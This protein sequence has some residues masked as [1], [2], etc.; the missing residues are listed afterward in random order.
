MSSDNN[1][2]VA[3][4]LAED[5]AR[6]VKTEDGQMQIH[7]YESGGAEHYGEDSEGATVFTQSGSS[8]EHYSDSSQSMPELEQYR[9]QEEAGAQ[10]LVS[11]ALE[12]SKVGQDDDE[13]EDWEELTDRNQLTRRQREELLDPPSPSPM[14]LGEDLHESVEDFPDEIE[15]QLIQKNVLLNGQIQSIDFIMC[16][17]CPRLFRTESL[18]WNHIKA[19]HKRRSYR[20]AAPPQIRRSNNGLSSGLEPG[21]IHPASI[22]RLEQQQMQHQER[23]SGD[24][25]RSPLKSPVRVSPSQTQQRKD[26]SLYVVGLNREAEAERLSNKPI[27]QSFE[28][29]K[30]EKY[31]R[32]RARKRI[33]VDSNHGP[34]KCPGCDAVTFSNRRAL[35]LHMRKIHKAGIMEC[36]ECGRKVLDL[37]RHKEILHKRFKIYNCPHCNDKYCTQEDL[38]RHLMKV[39]KN[40]IVKGFA[41]S[42]SRPLIDN[43]NIIPP[44]VPAPVPPPPQPPVKLKPVDVVGSA[45]GAA[46]EAE[47]QQPAAVQGFVS[48]METKTYSCS[49][50]GLKTPSRMTYIQH[51][52]NGCIMDMV[53]G[54]S[55][56]GQ[57]EGNQQVASQRHNR[58]VKKMLKVG[59]I[60]QS[61]S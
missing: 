24:R 20:R 32:Q 26:M 47:Q 16:N 18:L 58:P 22:A 55:E 15:C 51:V 56:S 29:L 10:D 25:A 17:Q 59:E 57:E 42:G 28:G 50:C 4:L 61:I 7:V 34:F 35:D 11:L 5:V 60:E 36:D 43:V 44:S 48:Q 27:E 40:N 14:D 37:K 31:Q 13:A 1:I 39:E 2:T 49:E 41:S 30:P 52:L 33:Y 53:M 54:S 19:K 3:A 45:V 23:T 8:L 9:G 46:V 21:E 12:S 6:V 38:E